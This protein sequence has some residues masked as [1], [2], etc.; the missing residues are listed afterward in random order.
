MIRLYNDN[1]CKQKFAQAGFKRAAVFSWK[2]MAEEV[3]N[4]YKEINNTK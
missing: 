4:I 3:L 2:A 1:D